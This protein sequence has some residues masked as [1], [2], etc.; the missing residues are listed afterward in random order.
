MIRQKEYLVSNFRDR[1]DRGV[2]DRWD[3]GAKLSSSP[4]R[5]AA[6]SGRIT[7]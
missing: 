5:T 4:L 7:L 2:T 6:R 1:G 3:H